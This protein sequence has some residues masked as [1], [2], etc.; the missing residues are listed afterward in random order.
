MVIESLEV[1]GAEKLLK[2]EDT[3]LQPCKCDCIVFT[4]LIQQISLPFTYYV[5][6]QHTRNL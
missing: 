1:G 6:M 5:Q 2:I 3:I 4:N